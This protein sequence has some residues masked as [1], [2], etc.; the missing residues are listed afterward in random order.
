MIVLFDFVSDVVSDQWNVILVFLI[1]QHVGKCRS[2]NSLD[3]HARMEPPPRHYQLRIQLWALVNVKKVLLY[4]RFVCICF[5][6]LKIDAR[7][8]EP[9]GDITERLQLM[10]NLI[11]HCP[12]S[13]AIITLK[14][15]FQLTIFI[16]FFVNLT[17]LSRIL[18]TVPVEFGVVNTCLH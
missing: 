2:S 12:I 8:E 11:L 16:W 14:V 4:C 17:W 3:Q 18:N 1:L 13:W 5:K 6:V 10:I 7:Y 15:E 9:L